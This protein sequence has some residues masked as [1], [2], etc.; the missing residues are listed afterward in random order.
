MLEN[1]DIYSLE[2]KEALRDYCIQY[3]RSLFC[4]Q[5]GRSWSIY[6]PIEELEAADWLAAT[7]IEV[8]GLA[9]QEGKYD[10]GSGSDNGRSTET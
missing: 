5:W 6:R 10:R 4:S 3:F 8:I 7:M 2:F 1:I 9:S